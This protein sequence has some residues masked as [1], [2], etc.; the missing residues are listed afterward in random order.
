MEQFTHVLVPEL[1]M[2]QLSM[3]LRAQT[4]IDV[5]SVSKVQGKPFKEVELV[6]IVLDV[7]AGKE[8]G[9][10]LIETLEKVDLGIDDKSVS[11]H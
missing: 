6:N 5:K 10:Y 11:I 1:N 9:P 3:V 4:L 8:V 2:G 7:L